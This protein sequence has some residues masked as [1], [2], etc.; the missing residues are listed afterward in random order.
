MWTKTGYFTPM[1][2]KYI[3][4]VSEL[5]WNARAPPNN[6]LPCG[7]SLHR[8]KV[9]VSPT[10]CW[11]HWTI[12]GWGNYTCS[13]RLG[14]WAQHHWT[15]LRHHFNQHKEDAKCSCP[16]GKH[17]WGTATLAGMPSSCPR[18]YHGG[19]SHHPVQKD[20]NNN[21]S[22]SSAVEEVSSFFCARLI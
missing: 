7:S 3:A 12:S 10:C 22:F 6:F 19:S 5:P 11:R 15:L 20:Y 4:C 1:F 9:A 16:T 2:L 13:R 18:T 21:W 14:M 17:A 8:R